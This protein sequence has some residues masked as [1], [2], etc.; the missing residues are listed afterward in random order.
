MKKLYVITTETEIGKKRITRL[1]KLVKNL[2]ELEIITDNND[3]STL[4]D[5][6]N[7]ILL[8]NKETIE[9]IFICEDDMI[10]TKN[11]NLDKLDEIINNVKDK[12]DIISL[13]SPSLY[14]F[15]KL[16]M[17]NLVSLYNL[18]GSH[19]LVILPSFYKKPS[20]Y[21]ISYEVD[22]WLSDYKFKLSTVLP[23]MAI[24]D[25]LG[26]SQI[27]DFIALSKEYLLEEEQKMLTK[28]GL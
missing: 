7:Y 16:I 27:R 9:P 18:Q 26:G 4:E 14:W 10:L 15:D 3:L 1:K 11:F 6:Y 22:K 13:G 28:F 20:P 12:V 21:N 8:S 24:Q 25:G 5:K 19:F 17:E 2:F 23:F